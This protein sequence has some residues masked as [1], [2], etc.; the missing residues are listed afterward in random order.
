MMAMC[1]KMIPKMGVVKVTPGAWVWSE[2][3]RWPPLQRVLTAP[4]WTLAIHEDI[5]NTL[6]RPVVEPKLSTS[7]AKF[8]TITSARNVGQVDA[9]VDC[10]WGLSHHPNGTWLTTTIWRD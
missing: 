4:F 10:H 2:S 8:T 5:R 9:D 1:R 6:A 3:D 7:D